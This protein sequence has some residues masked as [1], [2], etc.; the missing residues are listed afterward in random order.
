[1]SSLH[2]P[3]AHSK[4]CLFQAS[5]AEP[6]NYCLKL[7]S[8]QPAL[9]A[10]LQWPIH[11]SRP[12]RGLPGRG[13]GDQPVSSHGRVHSHI[14]RVLQAGAGVRGRSPP[15]QPHRQSHPVH[16]A[17]QPEP[18]H[19]PG[20][21]GRAGNAAGAG[22]GADR[23]DGRD[24]EAGR[25]CSSARP[26]QDCPQTHKHPSW[27]GVYAFSI[28]TWE[29]MLPPQKA[30]SQTLLRQ[31]E[32]GRTHGALDSEALARPLPPTTS[33]SLVVSRVQGSGRGNIQAVT[34][35]LGLTRPLGI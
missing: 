20:P 13:A 19:P 4:P 21:A 18:H 3:P 17:Q 23:W 12:W 15:V 9:N 6:G 34:S 7:P 27:L 24:G 11:A 29:L 16:Y 33:I 31:R 22:G 35:Q 8:A 2:R 32:P 5:S 30:R 1:M 10:P 26:S 25:D 14:G 28:P